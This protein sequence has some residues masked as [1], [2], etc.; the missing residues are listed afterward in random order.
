MVSIDLFMDEFVIEWMINNGWMK[1]GMEF[2]VRMQ[3]KGIYNG[4]RERVEMWLWC[5]CD[6]FVL[7]K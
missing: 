2:G 1:K 6:D 4:E 3:D 5:L 7:E